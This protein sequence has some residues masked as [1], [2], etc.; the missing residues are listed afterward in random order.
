MTWAIFHDDHT[1][2]IGEL[3]SSPSDRVTAVVGGALLD[4]HVQRTLS[5]RLRDSRRT[6]WL[7][8]TDN[9]LGN[10]GPKIEL[11]YILYA[12][13]KPTFKALKGI[14]G[15]RNFF[16]H[17][18]TASFTSADPLFLEHMAPL[19]LDVGKLVYPHHLYSWRDSEVAIEQIRNNRDWFI[20][21]LK[22]GLLALMQDRV[23]HEANGN[24]ALTLEEI[25]AKFPW[26]P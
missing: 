8:K 13:D 12:I 23:R 1:A 20:V 14:A 18:V 24:D 26:A 4:E 10:V 17:N 11:L 9:P 5:E 21:N 15:V 19:T 16:A 25:R 22:L 6:G 2:A 3:I 7:L